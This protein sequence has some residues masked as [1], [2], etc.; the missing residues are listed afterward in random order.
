M[1]KLVCDNCGSPDVVVQDGILICQACGTRFILEKY[2][3]KVLKNKVA[4]ETS[5]TETP[6]DSSHIEEQEDYIEELLRRAR[7]K[8]KEN[9]DMEAA[10]IA[11]KILK[12]DPKIAEAWLISCFI[13]I[14]L[15][16]EYKNHFEEFLT[17]FEKG[18]ELENEEYRISNYAAEAYKAYVNAEYDYVCNRLISDVFSEAL[19]N[20]LLDTDTYFNIKAE[21]AANRL[22]IQNIY[23]NKINTLSL[24]GAGKGKRNLKKGI[25]KELLAWLRDS[26]DRLLNHAELAGIEKNW[27]KYQDWYS[28]AD[29][30]EFRKFTNLYS[31]VTKFITVAIPENLSSVD[32]SK[33]NEL[34]VISHACAVLINITSQWE[35]ILVARARGIDQEDPKRTEI[36]EKIK[37]AKNDIKKYNAIKE[38]CDSIF[39]IG[40]CYIATAVYGSY[41]CPEV[42]TLRRFRDNTLA[43]TWYGTAFI[44]LYYK[45][46]PTLVKWFGNT[47]WFKRFFKSKLD[48]LVSELQKNGVENTPYKDGEW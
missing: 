11:D 19:S 42:W 40:G 7:A 33:R 25:G 16:H 41:D 12:H 37:Q 21:L 24:S 45:V 32:K 44:H 36:V 28:I 39:P 2:E 46:S 13:D 18:M 9:L 48:C 29:I 22:R 4:E 26:Q 43:K 1:K 31:F 35:D 34:D 17:C 14:S 27:S 38:S 10:L 15:A 6:K 8:H 20:K 5:H 3:K 23:D 30:K 47:T